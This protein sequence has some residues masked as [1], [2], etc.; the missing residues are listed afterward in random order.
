VSFTVFE[1]AKRLV[2]IVSDLAFWLADSPENKLMTVAERRAIVKRIYKIQ[3]LA[4][5][6]AR[7][8]K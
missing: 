2:E 5:K 1:M 6:L 3:T 7:R 8:K 4:L